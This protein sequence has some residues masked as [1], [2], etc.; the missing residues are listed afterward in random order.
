MK[1]YLTYAL[2]AILAISA[3]V[4]AF[5]AGDEKNAVSEAPKTYESAKKETPEPE[6]A[7]DDTATSQK[8]VENPI[9]HEKSLPEEKKER[10]SI[11]ADT[12][13]N[14]ITPKAE[15]ADELYCTLSVSCADVLNEI[16]Q[17]VPEKAKFLPQDGIIYAEKKVKFNEGESVFNVLLR[18]MKKSKIHMEF[19]KTP[20]YDSA[21]IEGISNLYEFDLGN[22][23]GWIYKVNGKM[24]DYGCS[25]YILS[26]G[27]KIEWIYSSE[28]NFG[29]LMGDE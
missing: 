13:V 14:D 3:L 20:A 22:L 12:P 16:S 10:E 4:F 25:K 15:T 26:P 11:P 21:Y 17:Y 19:V 29:G 1:K 7:P 6:T 28:K 18:E 2:C 27:D 8:E 5:N 24:P 9:E 23:S